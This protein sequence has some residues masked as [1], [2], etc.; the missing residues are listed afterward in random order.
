LEAN[1]RRV[2]N[3]LRN[4]EVADQSRTPFLVPKN[5]NS[6][7]INGDLLP[8]ENGRAYKN[9]YIAKKR[10]FSVD[11]SAPLNFSSS[12]KNSNSSRKPKLS[13]PTPSTTKLETVDR[14]PRVITSDLE[15]SSVEN[16]SLKKISESLN[17]YSESEEMFPPTQ[18]FIKPT[19]T[20]SEQ[21][22]KDE[23]S[24]LLRSVKPQQGGL[25]EHPLGVP[26][27]RHLMSGYQTCMDQC[28][29]GLFIGDRLA[30][31]NISYLKQVG[32]THVVN[33]AEGN[34]FCTVDTNANYYKAEG[35][36]Y[37]GFQL[38][39]VVSADIQQFF[40]P[41]AQF[42]DEC[43]KN[44]GRVLVHCFMGISRSATISAAFLIL[45]REM[46]AKKALFTLRKNRHIFPND[47]FLLQLIQME[48]NM[49]Q[50]K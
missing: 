44:N 21:E 48:K 23:L 35:I 45:K 42:I 33:T 11:N 16:Y 4:I 27:P 47:G 46:T 3:E 39:D 31:T 12:A 8:G 6:E 40:E 28:Y 25:Q 41:A 30:A 20:Q 34:G 38:L 14:L 26:T 24:N 15:E 49:V 1:P 9:F 18:Q 10:S 43:L 2:S 29:P 17:N 32:I 5:V 19:M 36:K 13:A 37:I 7:N 22:L 50:T